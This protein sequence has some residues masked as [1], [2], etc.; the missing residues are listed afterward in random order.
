[1][2]SGIGDHRF[3]AGHGREHDYFGCDS[4]ATNREREDGTM[5]VD[6]ESAA[7]NRRRG[8]DYVSWDYAAST[9]GIGAATAKGLLGHGI[10]ALMAYVVGDRGFGAWCGHG[11][12]EGILQSWLR[13]MRGEVWRAVLD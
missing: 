2:A 1:M 3:E 13:G 4:A 9:E 5:N 10:G 6:G 7:T 12:V 11:R 8:A